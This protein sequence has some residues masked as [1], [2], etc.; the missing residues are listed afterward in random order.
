MEQI[1]NFAIIAHIDHGKSTLA[2][3]F[4]ELTGTIAPGKMSEQVLDKMDIE[5]ERG[6]TIKLTPVRMNYQLNG[7]DYILNL[8]DTPGHVDFTYEV[9][10]ALAAVEGAILLVDATKG[11]QAQTIANLKLARDLNLVIIPAINK[12]DLAAAR[13]EEVKD[14]IVN[15]LDIE[16]D[17][18]F[19]LSAKTG[20][21]VEQLIETIISK[22]PFPRGESRGVS[23]ALIFDS[24]FDNYR[25]VVAHVRM[26]DGKIEDKNKIFLLNC[27]KSAR[28]LELGFFVP[29]YHKKPTLEAG[30]IGYI[31]TDLRDLSSVPVG[32]TATSSEFELKGMTSLPGY[33]KM[34]PTVFA[35]F[36]PVT[37]EQSPALASS[38]SKLQLNDSAIEYVSVNSKVLGQGFRVGCLGMLHLEIVKERLKREFDLDLIITTPQVEFR[39][40]EDGGYMEPFVDLEIVSPPEYIGPVMSLIQNYRATYKNT[41]YVGNLTILDFDCPLAEVIIDFYDQLKSKTNGFA[42]MNYQ[43]TGWRISSLSKV[44]VLLN[45][46]GVEALERLEHVSKAKTVAFSLATKLKQ[47]LP[48]QLFEVRIQVEVDHKI[49]ASERISPLRKDV[50][51]KLYGGDVTRKNKLLEKQKKGKKKMRQIGK[52]SIPPEVFYKLLK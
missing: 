32:D 14:E 41:R 39:A 20:Q 15:L 31:V 28:I 10:R 12:V 35:S 18:I 26:I 33:K 25:G 40:Q 8:V 43:L 38:L 23:R 46:E 48:R 30:E 1:R 16:R 9:S 47:Y 5:R 49:V 17:Q 45:G 6:I 36:F 4:L 37:G 24:L 22:I 19:C 34:K 44:E 2:D 13:I 7:Q 51:A 29:D 52:M 11:V 42:T 27:G 3:R 50:T 21:G